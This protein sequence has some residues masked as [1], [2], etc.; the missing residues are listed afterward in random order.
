LQK[1][2]KKF[3]NLALKKNI[4]IKI[5]KNYDLILEN[6]I[7]YLDRFFGNLINNSINYNN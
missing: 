5:I 2:I 3:E 4:K 1:F 6:N 7:Y